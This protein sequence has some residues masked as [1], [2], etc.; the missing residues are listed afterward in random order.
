MHAGERLV[1]SVAAPFARL[2]LLPL[3]GLTRRGN[4][5]CAAQSLVDAADRFPKEFARSRQSLDPE[6]IDLN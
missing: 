6:D 2:V 4:Q 3:I 1:N 5:G